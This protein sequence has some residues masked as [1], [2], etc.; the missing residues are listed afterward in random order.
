MR[1]FPISANG[2]AS[3]AAAI[4]H[5]GLLAAGRD[6]MASESGQIE[7]TAP[8][9]AHASNSERP[10]V[11]P[12]ATLAGQE[13][14]ATSSTHVD[15]AMPP[16]LILAG[17][18]VALA[19]QGLRIDAWY[20]ASL[21]TTEAAGRISNYCMV[22]DAVAFVLP[23]VA[24]GLWCSRRRR[25]ALLAWMVWCIP[26]TVAINSTVGFLALNISDTSAE[27]V[28]TADG[29]AAL[30]T[31]IS[32]LRAE[33]AGV[34]EFRPVKWFDAEINAAQPKVDKEVWRATNHCNDVTMKASG[35]ACA[36]VLRLRQGLGSAQ[37]R[38]TMES[39]L[40]DAEAQMAALPAI[41]S[42][43]PQAD[44]M[45]ALV[46]WVSGSRMTISQSDI[47]MTRLLTL[48]LLQQTAGLL[49]MFALAL[50]G[51][52]MQIPARLYSLIRFRGN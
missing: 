8:T 1:N 20:G 14:P 49:L 6:A 42:A 43:D 11:G 50:L 26:L 2:H 7:L 46:S 15:V 41:T 25:L 19:W 3:P 33:Q 31:R 22:A 40:R 5:R 28:K 30:V 39:E 13:G 4:D 27:R 24:R 47:V 34:A 35:E 38:D 16:G 51:E 29:H 17:L 10:Q 44:A 45:V 21:E 36:E 18:A 52:A 37:R 48:T 9:E 23:A 32:R 12:A